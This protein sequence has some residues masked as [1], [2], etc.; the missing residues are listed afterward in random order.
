MNDFIG[1]KSYKAKGRRLTTEK[2]KSLKWAE[3]LPY[4]YATSD[5]KPDKGNVDSES[6]EESTKKS[7]PNVPIKNKPV[8]SKKEVKTEPSK[9]D[10]KIP[11]KTAEE[12]SK[13]TNK[14]E[15]LE[16]SQEAD[17]IEFEIEMDDEH[18]LIDKKNPS[19]K[20]KKTNSGN[21]EGQ[22]TIDFD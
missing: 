21:F 10:S 9:T 18:I 2:I 6:V 16:E 3:P 15:S 14:K 8:G 7:E 5:K 11:I 12:K 4:S 19:K 22:A 1:I 17:T 13:T 20:N